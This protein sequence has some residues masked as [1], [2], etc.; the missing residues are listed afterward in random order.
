MDFSFCFFQFR[1]AEFRT[2]VDFNK[3]EYI[4]AIPPHT[5]S[6]QFE[7]FQ[8]ERIAVVDLRKEKH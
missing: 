6:V 8:S 3:K 2:K 1:R 5:S 7:F 4:E